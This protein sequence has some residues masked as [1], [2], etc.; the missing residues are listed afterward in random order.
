MFLERI[1]E[2]DVTVDSDKELIA[3]FYALRKGKSN[4]FGKQATADGL[5]LLDFK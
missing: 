3:F 4:G 1:G 2:T 5:G